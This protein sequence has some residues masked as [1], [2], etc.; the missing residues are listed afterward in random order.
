MPEVDQMGNPATDR[1]IHGAN[2][3]THKRERSRP[4]VA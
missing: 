4:T 1:T 3:A 2:A